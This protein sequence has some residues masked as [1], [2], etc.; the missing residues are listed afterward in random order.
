[1]KHYLIYL[2]TFF[3]MI[4]SPQLHAQT[5]VTIDNI[6]YELDGVEAHVV[7]YKGAPVEITIPETITT[8]G[9]TFKVTSI[10]GFFSCS[11][12]VK[13]QA[14]Y[15]STINDFSGCTNLK[16]VQ[17]NKAETIDEDA[18]SG[19]T[20]LR[21]VRIRNIRKIG[22][23]AFRNCKSLEVV[24]L[25]NHPIV[26]GKYAFRD[27][28]S[29]NYIVLNHDDSY[30]YSIFSGCNMLQSII[31][32]GKYNY[33]TLGS[34][35]K[36]YVASDL[37]SWSASS[38][39]YSGKSPQPLYTYA[40]PANFQITKADGKL[41]AD[42]GEYTDSVSFTFANQ[43]MSFDVKIPYSYTVA[44]A[45]LNAKVQNASKTYGDENPKFTVKYS[46]FE[47]GEDESVLDSPGDIVTNA[48]KNSDVGS[49]AISL[50][51]AKDNNY[52]ITI[53]DGLLTISKAPLTVK[54]AN[55]KRFYGSENPVFTL[56]YEG[57]KNYEVAPKWV[58]GPTISCPADATSPVGTY[59][60]LVSN[61]EALNYTVSLGRGTLTVSKAPLR[62]KA[63]NVNRMYYEPNPDFKCSY[64]GFVNGESL[65]VLDSQ[66]QLSTPAT[67]SSNAGN[68]P[69]NISGAK[70]KNYDI[71]YESG[72]LQVQKRTLDVS[73]ESYTRPFNEENPKFSISY[74]GFVNGEDENVLVVKPTVYT[75]AT[76]TSDVGTYTLVVSGGMAD[77]YDFAYN[78][79]SLIIEKAYQTIDWDQSLENIPLYSQ[80]ELNAQA[81]SNL[82]V[83]YELNNDTV[84][85]LTYIGPRTYLD[86]FH[87]GK[88]T[89][90]AYQ[91]GSN[92]YW[93]T[94]KYYKVLT[95]CDP[96][97]IRN[98]YTEGTLKDRITSTD[99]NISVPS[100]SQ[101]EIIS[102]YSL[103]GQL[104]YSGHEQSV[105][106]G[107]GVFIVR[108]GNKVAKISVK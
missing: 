45:K 96:T 30:P 61:C 77:N 76:K 16:S 85:N 9:L 34:N 32:L 70:A 20:N 62:L 18:F 91:S 22:R 89:I 24:D 42:V 83:T 68:Y 97:G 52:D 72:V 51:G 66:P 73:A 67:L 17:A 46:G 107:R 44:K 105:R 39:T 49:Y 10:S 37:V 75:N 92:N 29:L 41:H 38:F 23:S 58:F 19:C 69:I 2:M 60:I 33:G 53:T 26:F 21:E 93:P 56:E 31:Y 55:Q 36:T 50:Q 6:K 79:G 103:T 5:L 7:G 48:N 63:N 78:N 95:V 12:L 106:T 71:S 88:V 1:M 82:E 40:A 84:C 104:L 90:A 27:C 99:G 13:I 74:M 11:S 86:C 4:I 43:D 81:S 87:D 100:L 25:G 65:S 28:S 15:V 47:D 102:V 80:V 101:K 64:Y 94:T 108:I 98:A 14:D 35:A 59:D 3:A 57:L 54:P 8:N